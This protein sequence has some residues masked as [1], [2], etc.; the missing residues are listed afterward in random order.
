MAFFDR[1]LQVQFAIP[2]MTCSALGRELLEFWDKPIVSLPNM[3]PLHT[4]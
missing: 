3:R 1:K 2:S 4:G